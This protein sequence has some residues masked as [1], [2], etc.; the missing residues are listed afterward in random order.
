MVATDL[1]GLTSLAEDGRALIGVMIGLGP[2]G[3][4]LPYIL[5]YFIVEPR[6]STASSATYIPPVV[7]LAIGWLLVDD[8][9]QL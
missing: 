7:A 5:Y 9:L 4:G 8:P 1:D 6:G 3:T 2:L